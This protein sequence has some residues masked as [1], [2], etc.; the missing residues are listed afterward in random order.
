MNI[1]PV[2]SEQDYSA[3]LER[4][5]MLWGAE[6]GTPEGDE[7]DILLTLTCVYEE[8]HH[9]VPPPTP[10][11]AIKFV[12][13][14]KNLKPADLVP[15]IGS[16]SKVSEILNGK[17]TLTLSMIRSLNKNIGIPAEVLIQEGAAFPYNGE[18]IKWD[19][20]PIAEIVNRG[21]VVGLD[22][23]TQAEEIMRSLCQKSGADDY[24]IQQ[25][26][27][28]RLRQGVRRNKEDNLFAVTAWILGV[29]AQAE[30]IKIEEEF[31]FSNA[32]R[33]LIS[34]VVHLSLLKEGPLIA[35]EYLFHKGIKLLV[36]PHF[37][38]TYLD[39]AVIIGNKNTPV[40]ALTLRHDRLD[41]F[42]FTLAHELAHLVLGHV[43]KVESKCIA[44]DLEFTEP[45]DEIEVEADE[46]AKEALLPIA[47]WDN[48]PARSTLR[49]KD[50]Y[51]LAKQAEIHPAIVAGRIRHERKNYR[52]LSGLIGQGKV[53][54]FFKHN[55]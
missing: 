19:S 50:V 32:D 7:L 37:K 16:R 27:A 38:K 10:I 54:C 28:C 5:E 48:H 40:I 53:R 46:L 21:W 42:W 36:V 11:E 45:L 17:R 23:N 1:R 51:D 25:S 14:R 15:F 20:F 35:M 49:A 13:D 29:L 12:M 2:K 39:G 52:I 47:L 22:P 30:K 44:D 26:F 6:P 8:A 41:N 9:P 34:K 31:D 4:I 24:F 3:A 55:C 43:Y 18:A 33:N